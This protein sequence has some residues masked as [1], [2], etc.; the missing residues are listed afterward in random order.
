MDD[1]RSLEPLIAGEVKRVIVL[2]RRLDQPAWKRL[3]LTYNINNDVWFATTPDNG[4]MEYFIQAVDA[5]GNVTT[6]LDYG[7]PFKIVTPWKMMLPVVM[8]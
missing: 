4:V 7:N 3:D 5:A 1:T 8:R 6:A 2:Y